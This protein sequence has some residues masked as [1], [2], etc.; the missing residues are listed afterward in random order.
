MISRKEEAWLQSFDVRQFDTSAGVYN[1]VLA[2]ASEISLSFFRG[3][4]SPDPKIRAACGEVLLNMMRGIVTQCSPSG[5]RNWPLAEDRNVGFEAVDATVQDGYPIESQVWNG[6]EWGFR[7]PASTKT[8]SEITGHVVRAEI[9]EDPN[10]TD[11]LG[12]RNPSMANARNWVVDK[13]I[14][15]T[16]VQSMRVCPSTMEA[17]REKGMFLID[18]RLLQNIVCY[19]GIDDQH[20]E[21]SAP[22][23]NDYLI[24]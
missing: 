14:A 23:M 3:V 16:L 18:N 11:L 1:R 21:L 4:V 7:I 2:D 24:D 5:C 22:T 9:P 12:R 17:F 19:A 10:E 8:F 13:A 15:Y 20:P 6:I